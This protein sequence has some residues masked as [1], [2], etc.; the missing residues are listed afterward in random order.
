MKKSMAHEIKEQQQRS[1]PAR[2]LTFGV[3][4][5]MKLENL[6]PNLQRSTSSEDRL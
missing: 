5:C 6:F 2:F 4:N 1:Q 3:I